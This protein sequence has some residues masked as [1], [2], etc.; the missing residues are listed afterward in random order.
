MRELLGS[1]FS[2]NTVST[3]VLR[4]FHQSLQSNAGTAPGLGETASFQIL[5][6]VLHILPIS[7][8]V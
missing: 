5:P 1:N 7:Y 2:Q 8:F 4:G 6:C 3:E